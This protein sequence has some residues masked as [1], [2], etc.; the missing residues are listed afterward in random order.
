MSVNERV[1]GANKKEREWDTNKRENRGTRVRGEHIDI[2]NKTNK[3]KKKYKQKPIRER[4]KYI[5]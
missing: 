1:K 2:T 3:N 5:G 4:K